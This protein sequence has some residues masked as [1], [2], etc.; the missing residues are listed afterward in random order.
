MSC[1]GNDD[2]DS[3]KG[4]ERE[5]VLSEL[6]DLRLHELEVADAESQ[7]RIRVPHRVITV[8]QFSVMALGPA[9][10]PHSLRP[11]TAAL[12]A[13]TANTS[14]VAR[15]YRTADPPALTPQLTTHRRLVQ[16]ADTR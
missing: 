16:L 1:A 2:N 7:I 11:T 4:A 9:N 14:V 6:R 15:A 13:L 8:K 5:P 10:D 12:A 3:V